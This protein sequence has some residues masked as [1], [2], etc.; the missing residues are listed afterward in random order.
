LSGYRGVV[1][2]NSGDRKAGPSER[3]VTPNMLVAYNMARWRRANGMT[4]EQLGAEL[5]GWTKIAVSAAERSWD[6]GRVRKF[7]ADLIADLASIFR[8]PVPAFFLPPEDDGKAARYVIRGDG[9]MVP[10]DEY[11]RLLM[12]EPDWEADTPAAVAYQ[13]AVIAA[14][15][16]YVDG[17]AAENLASAVSDLAAAEQV[18]TALEDARANREAIH[19]IYPVLDAALREN[20][21][22]QDA[23]E[24]ALRGRQPQERQP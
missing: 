19:G 1:D 13:Q 12:P 4:Q 23:L 3:E 24:R 7:D 20:A 17:E 10:M 18:K 2:D 5:G 21:V 6:G 8:I 11:F 16:K 22:L 14:T 9:G 15:A